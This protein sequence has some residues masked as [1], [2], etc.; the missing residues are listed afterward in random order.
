MVEHSDKILISNTY[1]L[2]IPATDR[3]LERVG[4]DDEH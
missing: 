4:T 2:A 3:H 1:Y